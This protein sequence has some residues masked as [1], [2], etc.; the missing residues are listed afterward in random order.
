MIGK[1]GATAKGER[2]VRRKGVIQRPGGQQSADAVAGSPSQTGQLSAEKDFPIPLDINR[3]HG[4][5][6]P[7]ADSRRKGRLHRAIAS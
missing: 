2:N 7:G 1:Q 4:F 6:G 3:P 5:V